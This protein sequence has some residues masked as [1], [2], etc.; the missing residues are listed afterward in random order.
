M[1][2]IQNLARHGARHGVILFHS[3]R[4]KSDLARP[5]RKQAVRSQIGLESSAQIDVLTKD[6]GDNIPVLIRG[7]APDDL[8]TRRVLDVARLESDACQSTAED[9]RQRRD[10][11][12][13]PAPPP[14]NARYIIHVKILQRDRHLPATVGAGTPDVFATNAGTASK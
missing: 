6:I 2:G 12:S 3:L 11:P 7:K 4:R 14:C 13:G 9:Y 1:T 10:D 5:H 8:R